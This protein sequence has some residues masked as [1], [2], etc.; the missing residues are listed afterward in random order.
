V[1]RSN[2]AKTSTGS[3]DADTVAYRASRRQIGILSAQCLDRR[4]P[5][6]ATLTSEVGAWTRARNAVDARVRRM[7]GVEQARAKSGHAYPA[8]APKKAAA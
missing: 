5:D 8:V 2:Q 6:L 7:F 4:I 3:P 1:T